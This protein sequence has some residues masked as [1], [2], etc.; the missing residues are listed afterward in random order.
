[1][2]DKKMRPCL[3]NFVLCFGVIAALPVLGQ[4]LREDATLVDKPDG[5]KVANGKAGAAVKIKR[6]QGFWAEVELGDKTGWVQLGKLSLAGTSGGSVALDTG[7]TGTG[8]IVSTSSARGL[9]AKDLLN[10]KPDSQAVAKL[11]G[12]FV[13]PDAVGKFR[14][15]GGIAVLP[16]KVALVTPA[17]TPK[18]AA[19]E[20]R[21]DD[22]FDTPKKSKKAS[23][24]W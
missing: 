4:T 18:P 14:S 13:D 2:G 1:L 11:D 6:R 7:R 3:K 23:D 15:E 10:G 17:A 8:N 12:F 21:G 19:K 9:S 5:A 22:D 16:D 20:S 24:D